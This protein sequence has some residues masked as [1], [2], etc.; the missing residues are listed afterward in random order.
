MSRAAQS[1]T[2]LQE[3]A[4]KLRGMQSFIVAAHISPDPDAIGS[5][6][7]LARALQMLGKDASVYFCD[8]IPE[9][10]QNLIP[11]VPYSRTATGP[12]VD[13]FIA[14]D[15]AS[16][17]RIGPDAETVSKRGK[18][19]FNIDHHVS[20][21]KY[22]DSNLVDSTAPAAALIVWELL[23][24]LKVTPDAQLASL[25]YAGLM[26][27]TGSFCFSNTDSRA[28]KVAAE[29]VEAGAEPALVANE[30][31][32]TLPLRALKLQALALDGLEVLLGGK[33]S[34]MSISA[35]ALQGAE[36]K[37]EDAEGLIDLARRVAGA[38]IAVLQREIEGGWKF[39]LRSK[40]GQIDVNAIAGHFGGGGHRAA[41]GCK[42][43]G[44]G[45]EVKQQM[46]AQ[47][48]QALSNPNL[49]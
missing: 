1:Q 8:A 19:T 26:D 38:E 37:A 7:G 5:A 48:E 20:N 22:G 34:Y 46:L 32:F 36:A 14:I 33:V 18:Q 25:L 15:T 29:M 6:F 40:T 35:E 12:A 30:V 23:P 43:Q 27:D 21:E 9:R 28:L 49:R 44:T 41:A 24:H 10:M 3:L 2:E 45:A 47:L 4:E 31:Y 13:A 39:S 16:K 42:L 17:R 11:D